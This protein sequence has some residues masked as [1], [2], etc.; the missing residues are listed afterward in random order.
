MTEHDAGRGAE[1]ILRGR[2]R[3]IDGRR[4]LAEIL[5]RLMADVADGG[6][7][8]LS[9]RLSGDLAGFRRF[10]L[11]AALNRLRTLRVRLP[12]EVPA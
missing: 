8:A 6:L 5:D 1:T 10:E 4:C 2:E 11:A 7:D 12:E 3:Y 9:S